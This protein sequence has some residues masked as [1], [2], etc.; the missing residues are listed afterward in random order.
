ML[1]IF[2]ASACGGTSARRGRTDG[3]SSGSTAA[4]GTGAAGGVGPT[5]GAA[6]TGGT[7]GTGASTSGGRGGDGTGAQGGS[8]GASIGGSGGDDGSGGTA[9]GSG[10]TPGGAGGTPGGAGGSTA[11][12]GGMVD[13]VSLV[14]RLDGRLMQFPC[15]DASLSD[16]CVI[17]GYYVDGVLTRCSGTMSNMIL[18]HPIGG[19]PG[20]RYRVTMHFYGILEPRNYG[21]DGPALM[22]D[23]SPGSPDRD[24]NAPTPW[25]TAPGGATIPSSNYSTSEI[26]VLDENGQELAQYFL[27]ADIEESRYTFIIDY[28]KTI[29]VVG[30]GMV[31]LRRFEPSCR[32]LRNCG[33]TPLG[34]PCGPRARIVD[35]SAADPPPPP[36]NP[37]NGGFTQPGLGE[38]SD[39]SGQWW[40]IDV[41]AASRL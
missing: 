15:N 37:A 14:G 3:G 20:A 16:D 4:A 12:S 24:G 35:V 31:R 7:N 40:L 9:A 32:I 17:D 10:G 1:A 8:G 21:I 30:G 26:H 22:R 28:E 13:I 33:A 39:Q 25:A 41:T 27:N 2:I 11:G 38:P 5:G 23:A 19:T 36:G 6:G 18:D 34:P 29:E